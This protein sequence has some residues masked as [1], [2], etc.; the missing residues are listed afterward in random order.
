MRVTGDSLGATVRVLRDWEQV[1]AEAG[2]WNQLA[3]EN[4]ML[5]REWLES[6]WEA[7][8][9]PGDQLAIIA[10]SDPLRNRRGILPGFVTR[11]ILG[12][13][14]RLLGS[15]TVCSDDL[16]LLEDEGEP[17]E[18]AK[19]A[20]ECLVSSAFRQAFGRLDAVELEGHLQ[21]EPSLGR[22]TAE[23]RTAGWVAEERELAGAWR[24]KLPGTSEE[25]LAQLPKSRR[26]KANKARRLLAEG[27]VNYEFA[28]EW[29]RIGSLWNEFVRLHQ[30]RREILGEAGCF[31]DPRF[32]RFLRSAVQRFA[33]QQA[34]WLG[35]LWSAGQ[36]VGMNLVFLHRAMACVYQAGMD[37]ERS[38][39]DPGHLINYF[40]IERAIEQK[41]EWLDFLRGDEPYKEGWG[42]ERR[43]LC[44]SRCFAPHLSARL[45][46]TAL[47]AGRGLKAWS[48][49]WLS[50][51]AAA[52]PA[53]SVD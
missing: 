14:Y 20:A 37:P 42:A 52:P 25:L 22:L 38:E 17:T 9:D 4:F 29:A 53:A 16:Q 8:R 39:L 26:R 30:K 12:R 31:S 28:G 18:F 10:W 44:R 5:R 36:P 2:D 41:V 51:P 49:N 45:R 32:E 34:C 23:L 33:G 11:G 24:V 47:A 43:V 35:V 27:Q 7:M 15:G 1:R 48:A 19:L 46:Q 40:M 21:G 13:T 50:Q 3:G 6:W